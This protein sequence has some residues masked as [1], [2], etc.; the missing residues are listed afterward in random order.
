[1]LSR[2]IF[3]YKNNSD[4]AFNGNGKKIMNK[5]FELSVMKKRIE[6]LEKENQV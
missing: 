5:E 4:L 3:E 6:E 2:W 1:M